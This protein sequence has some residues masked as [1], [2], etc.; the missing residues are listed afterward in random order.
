[1]PRVSPFRGLRYDT[2]V[3]GPLRRLTAPPYDVISDAD[4]RDYQDASGFSVVHLDLAQGDHGDA[5]PAGRYRGAGRLLGRWQQ[6]GVVVRD[7]EPGYYAYEMEPPAESR[8]PSIRGVF[9][10]MTLEPWGGAVIPHERTMSGPIR[11]RLDLLEATETHLSAVYGTVPGPSAGLADALGRLPA[12]D[13]A[14]EV[15]D[16]AGVR[17]RLWLIGDD[18]AVA[19]SLEQETLLIADGHHRYATALEYRELRHATDGP[20]PWDSVLT[21]IVDASATALPV[22]PFHRVQLEGHAPSGGAPI[23]DLES[24]LD[25]LSDDDVMVGSAHR[26]GD[27]PM[28]YRIHRLGAPPPAVRALHEQVLGEAEMRFVPDAS[29]AE[30]S[31]RSGEAVAAWFLPATTPERI[32]AVV[33]AGQRLPQKSTY[34]WPKPRTGIVM[35]PLSD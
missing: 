12:D 25:A 29:A 21:L 27:G 3:A 17:H 2:D 33:E 24:L 16:G 20:G 13:P 23:E 11:D 22:L 5:D 19:R 34:F 8:I 15:T 18:G 6:A 30:A 10:A 4:R 1:M 32:R 9:V 26:A 35:M 31:V 14:A 28:E 7:P